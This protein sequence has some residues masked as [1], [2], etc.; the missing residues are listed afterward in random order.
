MRRI[1]VDIKNNKGLN[2]LFKFLVLGV[3]LL[4]LWINFNIN[5]MGLGDDTLLFLGPLMEDHNGSFVSFLISR[6]NEWSSRI[7]IEFFTLISVKHY[8]FWRVINSI[9]MTI[10]AVSPAFF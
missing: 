9:A 6:Y 7:I 8:F 4:F 3:F 5:L 1:D 10:L 2:T